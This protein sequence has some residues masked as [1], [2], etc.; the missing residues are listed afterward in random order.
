MN[1]PSSSALG[2]RSISKSYYPELRAR[3]EELEGFRALLDR[4]SDAIFVVDAETGIILD[5]AGAVQSMLGCDADK[6]KGLAFSNVLPEHIARYAGNLFNN[7]N[8]VLQLETE[9]L[10]PN[11]DQKPPVPVEMSLRIVT[12]KEGRR[13]V[14]VARDISERRRNEEALRKSHDE[15]EIRGARTDPGT[16]PRQPGQVGI[17]VHR[18]P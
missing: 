17:P 15:L 2:K 10:C 14:I 13:V 18:L 4:V 11:C 16:G 9:F 1:G 7:K 6:L 12:Q 8:D 5:V 3:L